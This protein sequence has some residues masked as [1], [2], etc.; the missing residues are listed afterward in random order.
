MGTTFRRCLA[1]SLL[2]AAAGAAL[3]D[4][5]SSGAT[6]TYRW[7]DAQ[8]V[9]HY[10]DTPQPGAER[11]QIQPAQTFP[12]QAISAP[13]VS[14]APAAPA[15]NHSCV[16]TQPAAEQSFY[17]PDAVVVSVQI[18]PRLSGGE[19]LSVT[20]DGQALTPADDSGLEFQV[21][22]PYR[23]AHTVKAVV[24]NADGQTVC[25]APAVTFYVQ[26]PSLLSPDSPAHGHGAPSAPGH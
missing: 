10:S 20:M 3:G 25:S 24:R 17:A 5:G 14:S 4:T 8:G 19:Q 23:G 2:V 16:I 22:S 12:D 11:L 18:A 13:A 9:V 6:T 15:P 7:V 1:L 21:S 26:R